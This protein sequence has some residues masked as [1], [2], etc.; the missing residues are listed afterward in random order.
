MFVYLEHKGWVEHVFHSQVAAF[1]QVF[2]G[3]FSEKL[4]VVQAVGNGRNFFQANV[5]SDRQRACRFTQLNDLITINVRL[6]GLEHVS[7]VWIT[8]IASH[9]NVRWCATAEE[10]CCRK[11]LQAGIKTSL[12]TWAWKSSYPPASWCLGSSNE[13]R[14][15]AQLHR[16]RPSSGLPAVGKKAAGVLKSAP[17]DTVPNQQ[18]EMVRLEWKGSAFN[19]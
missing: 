15:G 6:G 13:P 1:I 19:K 2:S 12:L 16:K 17:G 8:Q 14:R 9:A 4:D 11:L 7:H 18:G 10:V 5:C 3:K